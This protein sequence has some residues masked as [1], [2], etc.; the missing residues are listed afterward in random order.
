MT[1]VNVLG[2][3]VSR[4]GLVSDASRTLREASTR[5]HFPFIVACANPHSLVEAAS[6]AEFSRSLFA[7]DLLLPDGAGIVIASKVLGR[8]VRERVAGM[9][10]FLEYSRL[11]HIRGGI[12]Y[13]FLGSSDAVL[14]AIRDRV[15]REYPEIQVVGLY[16]PP[17]K[18]E[19]SD[20][21]NAEM[22]QIINAAAP[23]ALWVGMTAP[24]QEKWVDEH[25]D[26]LQVQMVASIGAVFDFYAGSKPRAPAWV[27]NIGL[28]WLPRLFREP[29][30]LARRNFISSPVF[31]ARVIG[32]K[33]GMYQ[34]ADRL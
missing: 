7:A 4:D 11:S 12:R 21:D 27:R 18:S 13:F 10:F 3:A 26:R 29:R 28:E 16:S 23:D 31:M 34:A 9:E 15:N 22:L 24:K 8:P 25:K 30:R 32:Q 1:T 6:D 14:S 33:L 2:Y 20:A 19:F 5:L 17:F